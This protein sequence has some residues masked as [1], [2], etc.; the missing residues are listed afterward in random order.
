L[1]DCIVSGLPEAGAARR[2]LDDYFGS[3]SSLG[4]RLESLHLRDLLA[5]A[6]DSAYTGAA[7]RS[8]DGVLF[9][10]N[11]P[12]EA[13]FFGCPTVLLTLAVAGDEPRER[14]ILAGALLRRWLASPLAGPREYATARV[15][16]DDTP[17]IQTLEAAGFRMLVPTVTLERPLL[18]DGSVKPSSYPAGPV[19]MAT[20]ADISPVADIARAAY[21]YG[22]YWVEPE[23]PHA[24]AA[25]MHATWAA[26]CVRGQQADVTF[27]ARRGQGQSQNLSLAGFLGAKHQPEGDLNIGVI[28]LTAVAEAARRQGIGGALVDASSDWARRQ[29]ASHMVVRT[30]LPNTPAMRLY[31]SRGFTAASAGIYF[32]RWR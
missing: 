20:E 13:G 28:V 29:G 7:G 2:I 21:I 11:K 24:V 14:H 22:R 3:A 4:R 1:E 32:A 25:E 19:E 16:A 6:A 12:W 5:G 31:E 8:A 23:L 17:A 10:E 27:V 26:N 30:E 18:P 9:V 15:A